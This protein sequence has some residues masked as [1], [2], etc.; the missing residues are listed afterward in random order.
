MK[1]FLVILSFLSI[2]LFNKCVLPN[3][4]DINYANNADHDVYVHVLD[5]RGKL[6]NTTYPD[7]AISFNKTTGSIKAHSYII[8]NI[9]TLPIENYFSNI[10]SDTLSVF[11]FHADTISKYSWEEI[12]QGYK[13]L[14]RY[15]LSLEDFKRLSDK[16]GVP[17]IIYPPDER[18]KDMK[19]YPPY[20]Q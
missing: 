18:M 13:I 19:M 9:G 5:N 14:Q 3:Y 10:P 17:V 8:V 1:S 7:T 15:D 16:N 4:Y 12:Q 11:Y 2:M 20:G 6:M